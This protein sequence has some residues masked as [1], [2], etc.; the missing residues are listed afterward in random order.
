MKW[1]LFQLK[2]LADFFPSWGFQNFI[3]TLFKRRENS[4]VNMIC[5]L[6]FPVADYIHIFK[7]MAVEDTNKKKTHF[8]FLY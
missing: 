7:Q 3:H 6:Y 1:N 4:F 2:I 5:L 8:N